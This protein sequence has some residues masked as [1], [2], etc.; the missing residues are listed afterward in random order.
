MRLSFTLTLSAFLLLCGLVAAAER[1]LAAENPP[2]ELTLYSAL[3][4]TTPQMPLWGAVRR[5]WPGPG[6]QL[7]V[8]YW[9][10]MDDLRGLL[11]AGKGSLWI[12]HLEGFAQAARRGAPVTLL[13]VTGWKKFY[14]VGRE[15]PP[16]AAGGLLAALAADLGAHGQALA[17]A[18][19]D[20]PALSLL[21]EIAGQGGP[22]FKTAALSAPQLMLEMSRNAWRYALL[23]EPLVSVLLL[24]DPSLRALAGLE[25][26]FA[27]RFG[28]PARLPLAGLAVH[29]ELAAACP[30][31]LEELLDKMR[32]AASDM[33][34]DRE[35]A[36]A[37]LP[38]E[39][40]SSLGK[41]AA[42][43]SL[44]RDLILSLPARDIEDEISSFLRLVLPETR[45]SAP[46]LPESFIFRGAR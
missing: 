5:G 18:P 14:F 46:A 43:A 37:A 20:S 27:G 3:S 28:G 40:L 21:E 8:E 9:K 34:K 44:E 42:L 19:R 7:K 29:S 11:L 25:D 22:V 39:V 31:L 30:E 1:G 26:E 23:P 24:K 41:E 17:V 38:A 2:Q 4:A 45:A 12:G 36:V 33:A 10:S 35:A 15:A 16:P 32:A 13:A 6:R